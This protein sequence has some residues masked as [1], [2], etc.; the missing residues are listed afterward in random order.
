[1]C[2]VIK[3]KFCD[4]KMALLEFFQISIISASILFSDSERY[5]SYCSM[6]LPKSNINCY[7]YLK[8]RVVV[9][10]W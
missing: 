6:C 8:C 5:V 2:K 4:I 1:M 9:A 3:E 10:K 7:I